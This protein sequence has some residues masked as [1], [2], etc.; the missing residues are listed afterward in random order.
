MGPVG[1]HTI[2]PHMSDS[3]EETVQEQVGTIAN[4]DEEVKDQYEA[5][6]EAD[7]DGEAAKPTDE[8]APTSDDK[9]AT[10]GEEAGEGGE[11][12]EEGEEGE[13]RPR[14][15]KKRTPSPSP[16]PRKKAPSHAPPPP[17]PKSYDVPSDTFSTRAVSNR[18]W[19]VDEEE[20]F[21]E[22][23][24]PEDA[25]DLSDT[26]LVQHY[27]VQ[28]T[29][30]RGFFAIVKQATAKDGGELVAVKVIDKSLAPQFGSG[31]LDS[32]LAILSK[33]DH[34][35]VLK[36]KTF[37]QSDS[38][39]MVVLEL[40]KGGELASVLARN[41]GGPYSEGNVHDYAKQLASALAHVHEKKVIHGDLSP[42]NVLLSEPQESATLKLGGFSGSMFV[43][44]EDQNSQLIGNAEY[45]APEIIMN[46]PF[47]Q[48][49]DCWSF[50]CLL[51]FLVEG[52]S[53]F[54]DSNTMR[55]NMKIRQGKVEFG[56]AWAGVSQPLKDLIS[57]LLRVDSASRLT[58]AQV[59]EH[60]WMQ[61]KP[62]A[63]VAL[64]TTRATMASAAS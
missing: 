46:Q 53:P 51:Y 37:Y 36:G 18:V 23:E 29:L 60:P 8:D 25:L 1:Y 41:Q 10:E 6:V 50:G 31:R 15:K 12:G 52:R 34:P 5:A 2:Y 56:E 14:R 64:P 13:D 22:P 19:E 54:E 43:A 55:M 7:E 49:A 48:S 47:G 42:E 44:E 27:N 62:G 59:L 11:E 3:Q 24:A 20:N 45:Q 63:G 33:L 9:P 21:S 57:Q 58:A 4:D 26:E 28:K 40:A 16:P 35:N 39:L 30:G 32:E 17:P 61:N 38:H